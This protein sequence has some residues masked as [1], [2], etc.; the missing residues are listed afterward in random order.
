MAYWSEEVRELH[1]ENR[2]KKIT[3]RSARNR[4][5]NTGARGAVMMPSDYM[6]KKQLEGMNGK[7]KSYK[8][9]SPMRWDEFKEMPDDL[10]ATYIKLIRNKYRTPDG[11][12]AHCMG[13]SASAF[14]KKVKELKLCRKPSEIAENRNWSTSDESVAFVDWWYGTNNIPMSGAF[15]FEARPLNH[16]LDKLKEK[17]SGLGDRE[18]NMNVSFEVI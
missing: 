6:T 4:R 7:C 16:I 10:Q 8:L 9:G 15:V 11:I 13:I 5:G 17:L 2:E 1:E 3:A 12:L 14:S 18:I